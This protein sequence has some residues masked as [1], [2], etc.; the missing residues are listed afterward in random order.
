VKIDAR[1]GIAR[2][3]FESAQN[4]GIA[5]TPN[6]K[7]YENGDVITFLSG[8]NELIIY[9]AQENGSLNYKVSFSGAQTL[10]VAASGV[11]ALI[12]FF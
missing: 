3:L 6:G 7:A 10:F 5:N 9:N 4:V 8:E 1:D 2:V 12:N 11:A